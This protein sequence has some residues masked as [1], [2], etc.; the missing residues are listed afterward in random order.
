MF[1]GHKPGRELDDTAASAA[2]DR[3]E[4]ILRRV[5]AAGGE[6]TKDEEMP[7]FIDFNNDT[8]EIGERRVIEFNL[9]KT[10]FQIIRDIKNFRTAG[11]ANHR[12]H[13]EAMDR[14][15]IE[16]KLKKKPEI[17]DQWIWMDF[18]DMF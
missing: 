2:S 9:N 5:K 7:L 8:V 1:D 12:K 4:E 10:D 3:L 11:S 13:L 15:M 14:P 6:I 16:T 17:S 18:E